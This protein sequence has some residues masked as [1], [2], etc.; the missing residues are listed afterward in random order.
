M[1]NCQA[2]APALPLAGGISVQP[3][4]RSCANRRINRPEDARLFSQL[5]LNCIS[6]AE[7]QAKR[8]LALGPRMFLSIRRTRAPT[9]VKT[10]E[11]GL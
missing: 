10:P 9:F 2:L 3:R 5:Q 8:A 7:L 1:W 11:A 6:M 4:G